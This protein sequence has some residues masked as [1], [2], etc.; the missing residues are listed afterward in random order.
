MQIDTLLKQF[1]SAI[2]IKKAPQKN[3][4]GDYQLD[5]LPDFRISI[6]ETPQGVFLSS[7]LSPVPQEGSK[8]AL[9]IYLMKANF[10]W[11]GTGGG[12]IGIDSG[13]NYFIFLQNLPPETNATGLKEAVEDFVNYVSYW[14]EEIAQFE[15][16][17]L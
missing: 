13:G 12:I 9:Y 6:R 16:T 7:L 4:A 1:T 17:P 2:G 11:Q 15:Q 8:E 14:K 10:L 5:L 3:K